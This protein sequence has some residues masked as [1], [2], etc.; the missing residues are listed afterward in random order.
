MFKVLQQ[1]DIMQLLHVH[2]VATWAQKK[3]VD[4]FVESIV[5][6]VTRG[7]DGAELFQHFFFFF[8]FVRGE[9]GRGGVL[10]IGIRTH[11]ESKI[12]LHNEW[13]KT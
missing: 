3:S 7:N 11:G 10:T 5:S 6:G 12:P 9:G 2:S 1:K 4:I 13:W 8:F